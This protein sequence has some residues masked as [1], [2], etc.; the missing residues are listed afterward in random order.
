MPTQKQIAANRRNAQKSTGPRT[1]KGKSISR[2]NAR[3]DGFT[4]QIIILDDEDRPHF[5][6][7]QTALIADLQ[8]KTTLELSLAHAI[9]WDTWRLNHLR[10]VET[11]LYALGAE[12]PAPTGRY[13]SDDPRLQPAASDAATFLHQSAHF[14]R[15][16]LY[17]QRLTRT[18]HK[19]L[20]TL[21][22]L[23]TERRRHESQAQAE[24]VLL[25]RASDINGL[26]YETPA[27]PTPNGFV[28][29]NAQI[30]AAA[31]RAS[32]LDVAQATLR[33]T[34]PRVQFATAASSTGAA[35]LLRWPV[36]KD[37][38]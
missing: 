6:K 23:Q 10:A 13:Q 32:A 12:N 19:N 34:P 36:T 35:E 22:G 24:E 4:G 18:L 9:A 17:E 37:A 27:S 26:P 30:H 38:A 21:R 8:P 14:D 7:F 33:E 20:A 28:F 11:N 29:S 3:R 15:L 1:E 5:E 25:A 31:H 16:G 2:L